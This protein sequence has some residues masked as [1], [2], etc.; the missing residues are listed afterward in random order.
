[1]KALSD[2]RKEI[3]LLDREVVAL[4]N[5]RAECVLGLAPLKRRQGM[6]VREPKRE[7]VVL[8][9]ILV[10]NRGPLP[11][12]AIERIYKAVIQEMRTVQRQRDD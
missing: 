7:S 6:P 9:N 5:R 11:N 3:D 10:S 1:M 8:D 4:L 2:W 12:Q